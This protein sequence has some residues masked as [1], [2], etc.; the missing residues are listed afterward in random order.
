LPG[1]EGLLVIEVDAEI[2]EEE[3]NRKSVLDSNTR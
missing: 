1:G 2:E 3:K